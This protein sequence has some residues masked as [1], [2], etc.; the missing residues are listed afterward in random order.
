MEVCAR[1]FPCL[2]VH[3]YTY[4]FDT[5]FRTDDG[6]IRNVMGIAIVY[7]GTGKTM[8]INRI[9]NSV[10]SLLSSVSLYGCG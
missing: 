5:Q 10:C 7:A 8:L 6:M 1:M 9:S 3:A 2:H 4:L